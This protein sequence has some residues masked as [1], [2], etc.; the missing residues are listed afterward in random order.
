MQGPYRVLVAVDWQSGRL[1]LLEVANVSG[2]QC[3]RLMVYAVGEVVLV[4]GP[5]LD[6]LAWRLQSL[7]RENLTAILNLK[8]EA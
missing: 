7:E 3:L 6:A 2:V 8:S 5:F 1:G 4:R